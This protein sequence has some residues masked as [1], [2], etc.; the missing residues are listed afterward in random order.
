MI[1]DSAANAS[2]FCNGVTGRDCGRQLRAQEKRCPSCAR[3]AAARWK[4]PIKKLGK[5][6]LVPAI[7]LMVKIVPKILVAIVT[8]GAVKLK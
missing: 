6:A 7:G 4:A 3:I 1:T 2:A 5:V 8:K